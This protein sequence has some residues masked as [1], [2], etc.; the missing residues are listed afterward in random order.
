MEWLYPRDRLA[1]RVAEQYIMTKRRNGS[2]GL[3]TPDDVT[4]GDALV[5]Q[6]DHRIA[7]NAGARQL[8]RYGCR[9]VQA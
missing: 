9:Q 4:P 6:G 7:E 8:Q 1:V 2:S 5:F 3:D